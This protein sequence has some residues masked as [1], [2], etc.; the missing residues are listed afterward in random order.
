MLKRNG[1]ILVFVFLAFVW[2]FQ[3][4]E[5]L[6]KDISRL[7]ARILYG[8][9]ILLVGIF[10]RSIDARSHRHHMELWA[11]L[12]KRGMWYFI[13][14]HYVVCR[15]GLLLAVFGAPVYLDANF[16]FPVAQ[17]MGLMSVV[18]V[19]MMSLLGY[20]EWKYCEQDVKILAVKRA[21]EVAR[22]NAALF[23]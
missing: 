20:L 6:E 19:V 5:S 18:L 12:R 10:W 16:A 21:A 15:G 7:A 23:N 9:A 17:T 3:I 4:G 1:H 22:E 14:I 8:T 11:D 13:L 2:G